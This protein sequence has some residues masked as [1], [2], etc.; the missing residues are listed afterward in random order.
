[1][2]NFDI[3]LSE[4]FLAK[5]P[6]DERAQAAIRAKYVLYL[7][8][9][10]SAPANIYGAMRTNLD[11]FDFNGIHELEYCSDEPSLITQYYDPEATIHLRKENGD[12]NCTITGMQALAMTELAGGFMKEL[13]PVIAKQKNMNGEG[14]DG[15]SQPPLLCAVLNAHWKVAAALSFC[16]EVNPN[17]RIPVEGRMLYNFLGT[18]G[19][20]EN[21]VPGSFLSMKVVGNTALDQLFHEHSESTRTG[22]L[23]DAFYD[24]K[25]FPFIISQYLDNGGR[26]TD[27]S[28]AL[29]ESHSSAFI[30]VQEHIAFMARCIEGISAE[31]CNLTE[32]K[33]A[34]SLGKLGPWFEDA[35]DNPKAREN[36]NMLRNEMPRWMSEELAAAYS[37]LEAQTWAARTDEREGWRIA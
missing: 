18:A 24:D 16:P 12:P 21:I 3:Q 5:F 13:I 31:E 23:R 6:P 33:M 22:T 34:F 20:L 2:S 35:R 37:I 29:M 4:A 32:F 17:V 11:H 7:I 8:M 27:Y 9:V 19:N 28:R 1:M 25:P 30:K 14:S 10:Q 15:L 36:L 26:L